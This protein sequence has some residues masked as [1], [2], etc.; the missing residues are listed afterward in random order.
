MKKIFVGIIFVTTM[1]LF[2]PSAT[3]AFENVP[4]KNSQSALQATVKV[5]G[6]GRT[7]HIPT[8]ISNV[9]DEQVTI[10]ILGTPGG[11]FEIYNAEEMV[12]YTPKFYSMIVWGLTLDPSQTVKM[13]SEIWRGVNYYGKKLPSGEYSVSGF[14][15]AEGGYIFSDPV[16]IHLEKTKNMYLLEFLNHFPLLERL[17][18]YITI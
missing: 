15:R 11:G 10:E 4:I 9:G 16:N 7:F 2:L 17:F 18:S 12:Y 14:V 8:Y 3:F 6:G 1:L 5:I 13:F